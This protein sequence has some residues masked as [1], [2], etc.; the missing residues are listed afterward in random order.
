MTLLQPGEKRRLSDLT[1]DT[2]VRVQVTHDLSGADVS[3]FGL[4]RERQLRDDR[5]FVFFNSLQSPAREVQLHLDGPRATFD[6]DLGA[7]PPSIERLV[8]VI[9][10]DQS[11]MSRL[12]QLRLSLQDPAGTERAAVQLTGTAFTAERALMIAELYRHSGEWRLG[13]IAQGFQGGLDALLTYFGGQIAEDTPATPPTPVPP[14]APTPTPTPPAPTPTPTPPA[15]TPPA[16]PPVPPADLSPSGPGGQGASIADFLR[17]SAEQDR[18]GE[19]FELE[20]SKMLEVK[21]NGRVWS[22]LGAMVAYKG[23]LDFQRASTL[24]DLMGGMRGGGMGGLL[25]AAMRMGSGEMGPLVSIQG[26]GVCYLADQGKEVS[27]IRLQGDTLNVSGNDLLA[28]EDTVT[29]EITMQRSVAGM[30]SGGLFSVRMSGYGLVAILSHG[31]PLT[32]RVTPQEPVFTDPN[33]TIAWSEH[34]RPDLRVAQDLRSMF[35]RGGGETLQMAFQG[36]GFV[37]VQPYEESPA[38]SNLPTH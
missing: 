24:S 11:P 5:Y 32:L 26:Q 36:S 23:R 38:M 31:K 34:L 10:H 20:S 2:R 8:F 13:S 3:V 16:P 9:S 33:A 22:K 29:H 35:G 1:P 14:P 28:F 4:D 19:V 18:P 6:V 37:I 27:I 30:V 12:G 17:A 7:L 21:V 25:G 15:P